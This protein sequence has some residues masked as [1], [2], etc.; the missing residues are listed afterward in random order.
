MMTYPEAQILFFD[1]EADPSNGK[2]MELA[3]LLDNTHIRT[4]AAADF[5]RFALAS[6]YCCGHNIVQHDCKLLATCYPSE[7]SEYF[8][9]L[10]KIDTLYLSALLFPREKYHRLF[11][12]YQLQAEWLNDPLKDAEAARDL[13]FELENAFASLALEKKQ[14]WQL[15][16]HHISGFDGFFDYLKLPA[17][18]ATLWQTQSLIRNYFSDKICTAVPIIDYIEKQAVELAYALN[19]IDAEPEDTG[20]L[21]P[22]VLHHYA[23]SDLIL[24]KLRTPCNE[25]LCKSKY[26]NEQQALIALKSYFGYSEFRSYDGDPLQE[27]AV[28]AALEGQSLLVIFP[29]GG[30]KSLTFQLPALMHYRACK[31]LTVVISPLQSLM[32][33]QVDVLERRQGIVKAVTINGLL[34]PLERQEAFE[35]VENG[36]AALLYIS[37]ESLRSTSMLKLL[38]KRVIA[39]FVID[40]AHCFS[41]W[42]Q[43]F[44]VDYL[45]V[46]DF[47]KK[48][49]E[50][51]ANSEKI[52]VSCFTATAKPAVVEDICRYFKSSMQIDLAIYQTSASRTNLHFEVI[53]VEGEEKK[54]EQL[55]WLL[56][57]H[58]CP[59]IVYVS[60]TAMT[61]IIAA[62]IQ[63]KGFNARPFHGKMDR[64]DKIAVMDLFMDKDSGI[65][66]VVA[67]SAFGMGVDKDDV[68]AVIHFTISDSLENYVQEAGRAGRNP[69]LNA[70]CYVLFDVNDLDQHFHLLNSTRISQKEIDQIWRGIKQFG[71]KN[72]VK[73]AKEIAKKAGWDMDMFEIET[74][75]KTA[76]S[77]LEQAKYIRRE[78]NLPR[79]FA[80]SIGIP[81]FEEAQKLIRK[82]IFGEKERD[83]AERLIKHIISRSRQIDME[84]VNIDDI[85]DALQI[86]R[87]QAMQEVSKLRE[88]AVL[89][90][91]MDLTAFVNTS[92]G[93]KGSK[94]RLEQCSKIVTTLVQLLF[95][96]RSKERLESGFRCHLRELNE[97]LIQANIDSKSEDIK[98]IINYL[99]IRRT[100]EKERIDRDEYRIRLKK[101]LRDLEIEI[102]NLNK[103]SERILGLLLHKAK[104]DSG[105]KDRHVADFS[106]LG[107]KKELEFLFPQD[108]QSAAFYEL[109]LL[110]MQHLEVIELKDGFVV[111]YNPM[112][113]IKLED[114]AKKGYTIDDYSRLAQYYQHK[115][116]QI[117]IAGEYAKRHLA[118]SAKAQEF[119]SDYF[120]MPYKDFLRRYFKE[121][122][123]KIRNP[124]TE[125][126]FARIVENLSEEQMEVFQSKEDKILVAAGPGSGKTRILV[127]KVAS[128]LLIEEVKPEQFL[129]L[130]FSRPAAM[131]FKVRLLELVGDLAHGVDI[132]TYHGFAFQLLGRL[133]NL[134]RSENILK[135]AIL[136]IDNEDFSSE[137][138]LSKTIL[139]VDEYQD[140]SADEYELLMAIAAKVKNM[141]MIFVGDDDQN[142]YEFR[143]ANI[144]YMRRFKDDEKAELFFL[145]TNY[146]SKSNIV[147]LSNAFLKVLM[148]DA[149]RMKEGRLLLSKDSR[150]GILKIRE[151]T[152]SNSFVSA[153]VEEVVARQKEDAG[154]KTAAV[155]CFSN[156]EAELIY[157]LL[158]ERGIAARL[159][160]DREDFPLRNLAE[161]KI[162]G[163]FLN[164][165]AEEGL[166]SEERWRECKN[167]LKTAEKDSIHLKTA[168][169]FIGAFEQAYPVKTLVDW[170]AYVSESKFKDAFHP[171][172][173]SIMISTM[174]KAKGKEFDRVWILLKDYPLGQEEKKR[175]LYVALTRAKEELYIHYNQSFLKPVVDLIENGPGCYEKDEASYP[176]PMRLRLQCGMNDVFLNHFKKVQ[177]ALQKVHAGADLY[178]DESSFELFAAKNT[179]PVLCLFS[180]NFKKNI[181]GF[182]QKGY[183]PIKLG[184]GFVVYWQPKEENVYYR[185]LL[186]Y[187]ELGK[188]D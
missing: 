25:Q 57:Q 105:N 159:I 147:A 54:K 82:N 156:D 51:K 19:A 4:K 58:Q 128:L 112:R 71:Q 26:C 149:L 124:I 12:G 119:V 158:N 90:D 97:G 79:I 108:I 46:A 141:R 167:R 59:V 178:L 22:W 89:K 104:K 134:E 52:P 33:D 96:N 75:V 32:K 85:S 164:T 155:L 109:S 160:G 37:P 125:E 165:V 98:S 148:K 3:G 143:G 135:E 62:Y 15:L 181:R 100:I 132:H 14:L 30:G 172:K 154:N 145:T 44:R 55:L 41:S 49:E 106:V 78:E 63:S 170:F 185:I 122:E 131:E 130:T 118:Q 35:R 53:P 127:H 24:K 66:I 72:F 110:Y 70:F 111:F 136:A 176:E 123:G 115:T 161:L 103:L 151:Y 80:N 93:S 150:K 36:Q 88:I 67:T 157:T 177:T 182:M 95:A 74:R 166:I 61:E 17:T 186:P 153:L 21:A 87:E 81:N 38:S 39:R 107:I 94:F 174:H 101:D 68:G 2:I 13:F 92:S 116:E 6:A 137:R 91:D 64:Q 9:Q 40:E 129:M 1:V 60:R 34:S 5:F 187:I 16:L 175:V 120:Q 8:R 47:I 43:D 50:A 69:K 23:E 142:I 146:R 113:I 144:E 65:D 56:N 121:R 162:F 18:S 73:S 138:V 20:F 140:V 169:F 99:E 117:H 163:D 152:R 29:T 173:Q 133:G 114:N 83:L 139:V 180:E 102:T 48:L 45:Y 188:E 31:A 76:I 7:Y 184:V 27:K 28:N 84:S 171:H 42:G 10:P 11:K 179:M 77:A 86:S 126:K 168:L 183:R